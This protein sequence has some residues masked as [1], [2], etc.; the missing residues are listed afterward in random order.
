MKSKVVLISDVSIGYG[1]PQLPLLVDW[2]SKKLKTNTECTI[3][4]PDQSE[5]YPIKRVYDHIHIERIW[6]SAHPYSSE[7]CI[8]FIK[9]ASKLVNHIDPDILIVSSAYALPLLWKLKKKPTF[10]IYYLLESIDTYYKIQKDL[11][12]H[13]NGMVD[14]ILFPEENRRIKFFESV[15]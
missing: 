7:G 15:G 3:I 14:L 10:T 5:K 12:K 6:S 11:N 8:H 4:E 9:E 13:L 2:I 1:N